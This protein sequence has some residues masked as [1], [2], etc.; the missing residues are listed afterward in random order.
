[1]VHS[2]NASGRSSTVLGA[3]AILVAGALLAG[4]AGPAQ[5][6]TAVPGSTRFGIGSGIDTTA[7]GAQ[8]RLAAGLG[9]GTARIDLWWTGIE[10]TPG[11]LVMPASYRTA[12]D[13][14]RSAGIR[15]L[16]VLDYGNPH[17]D[18][19][20]GPTS[21]DGIA[22]FA[23]YA[24]FVAA[25]FGPDV[26]GYE[27]W[28]EWPNTVAPGLRSASR[29]VALTKA[30]S[31]AVHAAAPGAVVAGP[32][33]SLLGAD[34][35]HPWLRQ[36]LAAGGPATVDAVSVHAYSGTRPPETALGPAMRELRAALA[37][38]H[39]SVPVWWTE[40]GWQ[41]GPPGQ[42]GTVSTA[43]QSAW[44]VR[45]G[46]LAAHL[47]AVLVVPFTLNDAVS[48]PTGYGLYGSAG[49]GWTARRAATAYAVLV[50]T[51][52]DRRFAAVERSGAGGVWIV[53]Y[54]S[55]RDVVRVAWSTSGV[56]TARVRV[57]SGTSLVSATGVTS[58]TVVVRGETAVRVRAA[59]VFLRSRR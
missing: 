46:A 5:A 19:G 27:V 51:V 37:A 34:G 35:L 31:A 15:P 39:R 21:A 52:G 32:A 43:V 56:R 13:R 55:G 48:T 12:V 6:A 57:P 1:M 16:I 11:D 4:V 49:G 29:Y 8:V 24:G 54:G 30:A 53:R 25:T 28:N 3:A 22:A 26:A 44:L 23:R 58:R 45:W 42:A 7:D 2:V 10:K 47:G 59:P 50:R 14:L 33:M 36:W 41:A 18:G 17:H 20:G 40:G 9:V 38:Q